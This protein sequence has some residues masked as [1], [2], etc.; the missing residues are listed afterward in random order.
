MISRVF[1]WYLMLKKRLLRKTG[2]LVILFMIPLF[3]FVFYL[4]SKEDGGS[5]LRI[6]LAVEN[7]EDKIA[8]E[9]MEKI[10]KDTAVF[11]FTVYDSEEDAKRK[12]EASQADAAWVFVDDMAETLEKIAQGK[13][14]KLVKIYESE[15]ST[16]LKISREKIFAVLYPYV[17]YYIYEDYVTNEMLPNEE[18]SE[19][20]LQEVYNVVGEQEGFIEFEYLNSD[21]KSADEVNFLTS[22][23][24]GLLM[25]IM[26]LSGIASTMYFLR[27]EERGVYSWLSPKKRI[28]VS[29]GNNLA[30][31]SLAGIFV[32][33]ALILGGNYTTFWRESI[34][35][36]LFIMMAAA[37]CS[38]LGSIFHSIN[39]LCILLPAIL[40]A[41]IVFC[42]VFFNTHILFQQ[43]LPPYFYLFSI[44]DVTYLIR[45]V[46]YCI[47]AYP[48]GYISN[49]RKV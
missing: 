12:V 41:C 47:I 48:L 24:R 22:T 42:P 7:K 11:Q 31:L 20:L 29:W 36:I 19:E 4:C 2:F 39:I 6:A 46:L 25:A 10:D 18:V 23:I 35:M 49:R 30:A 16:F 40:V 32:T 1:T 21:Q 34:A 27:D 17:A 3:A 37:F 13:D 38:L 8:V 15:E 44:N 26:L 9:I 14:R 43:I 33:I 45:M 28:F 5:F